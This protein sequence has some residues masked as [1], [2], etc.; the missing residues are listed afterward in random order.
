MKLKNGYGMRTPPKVRHK[1][2]VDAGFVK[3]TELFEVPPGMVCLDD[4]NSLALRFNQN[5]YVVSHLAHRFTAGFAWDTPWV[6]TD[7]LAAIMFKVWLAARAMSPDE[8]W[9][10]TDDRA[11]RLLAH[12]LSPYGHIGKLSPSHRERRSFSVVVTAALVHGLRKDALVPDTV[13]D[14]WREAVRAKTVLLRD[15]SRTTPYEAARELSDML[16]LA[17]Q[18]D[19]WLRWAGLL[20]PKE[21]KT[22]RDAYV[23]AL[24]SMSDATRYDEFNWKECF[25]FPEE[26]WKWPRRP[27]FA[28]RVRD[29]FTVVDNPQEA[30]VDNAAKLFALA[31]WCA[32]NSKRFIN[33]EFS[34]GPRIVNAGVA[35]DW[36]QGRSPASIVNLAINPDKV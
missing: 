16:R 22:D 24:L 36:M 19:R 9:Q 32:F 14:E 8:P 6:E 10:D 15:G 23:A 7:R 34:N 25:D 31:D 11:T 5:R 12:A 20:P 28:R 2:G 27:Q 29:L 1:K 3:R 21:T 33:V 13:P 18:E 26:L 35:L 17:C 4:R 30:V